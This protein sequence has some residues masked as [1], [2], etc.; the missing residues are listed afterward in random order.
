MK[1]QKGWFNE[2]ERHRLS[3]YG[4]KTTKDDRKQ[5]KPN[6]GFKRIKVSKAKGKEN[7]DGDDD[8]DDGDGRFWLEKNASIYIPS[9]VDENKPISDEEFQK[10]IENVQKEFTKMFGGITTFLGNGT[11]VSEDTGNF[12]KEDV[13]VVEVFMDEDKWEKMKDDIYDWLEEKQKEWRQDS[14]GFE[15]KGNMTFIE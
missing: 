3:A 1:N 4:I 15:F 7:D 5:I 9:T 14:I 2:R 12:I 11:Y 10:R 6:D 8:D 13:A